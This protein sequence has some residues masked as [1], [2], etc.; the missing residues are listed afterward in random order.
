MISRRP[1]LSF[2]SVNLTVGAVTAPIDGAS[3]VI[4]TSPA[5]KRLIVDLPAGSEGGRSVE[6]VQII[7]GALWPSRTR[8]SQLA[9]DTPGAGARR[10]IALATVCIASSTLCAFDASKARGK[11]TADG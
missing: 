5:T 7:R 1:L 6:L 11:N 10:S 9:A 4:P 2:S 3:T 8:R